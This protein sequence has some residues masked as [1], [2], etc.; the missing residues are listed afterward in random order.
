MV[1]VLA[2]LAAAVRAL[3]ANRLDT[4]KERIAISR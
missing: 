2:F 1:M 3:A 4:E